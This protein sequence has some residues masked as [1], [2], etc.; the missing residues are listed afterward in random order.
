MAMWWYWCSPPVK[1]CIGAGERLGVTRKAED[2]LK[3]LRYHFTVEGD[4]SSPHVQ[5]IECIVN[6]HIGSELL[7]L[8]D[9]Q[10]DLTEPC[11]DVI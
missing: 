11:F 4:E 6:M 3:S 7:G 9:L 10:V 8:E 2:L 1:G 5:L